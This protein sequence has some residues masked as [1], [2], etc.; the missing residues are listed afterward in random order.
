MDLSWLAELQDF[1][2]NEIGQPMHGLDV[3]IQ[4]QVDQHVRKVFGRVRNRDYNTA[5]K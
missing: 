5:S 1:E 2:P 4:A 3:F